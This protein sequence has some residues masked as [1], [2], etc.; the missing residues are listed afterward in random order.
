MNAFINVSAGLNDTAIFSENKKLYL[1]GGK[2]KINDFTMLDYQAR[3]S[4]I[5]NND[6]FEIFKV[7]H[8]WSTQISILY[9]VVSET[10]QLKA[11]LVSNQ[12]FN[13]IKN[14]ITRSWN[15]KDSKY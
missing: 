9:A 11:K 13:N 14:S 1:S 10:A 4:S 12:K 5:F 2:S 15:T 7:N 8:A 3:I 6:T